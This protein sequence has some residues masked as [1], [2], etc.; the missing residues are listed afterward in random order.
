MALAT[1]QDAIHVSNMLKGSS[2]KIKQQEEDRKMETM[3]AI[4]KTKD[5]AAQELW[6][7]IEEFGGLY[8]VSN[9]GNVR[10]LKGNGEPKTMK[11]GHQRDLKVVWLRKNSTTHC[12]RV[13]RLVLEA[14]LGAAPGPR[15]GPAHQD[16]DMDNCHLDNMHWEDGLSRSYKK[17]KPVGR[18]KG[19]RKKI[20]IEPKP[21]PVARK[22]FSGVREQRILY[23]GN[24]EVIVNITDGLVDLSQQGSSPLIRLADVPDM[25]KVLQQ[26]GGK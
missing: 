9:F 23:C 11:P 12:R 13:D 8:E 10:S 20:D 15:F 21:K 2:S 24:V 17:R 26:I 6:M 14:F 4:Q 7:P 18:P 16:G 5:G 1:T 22:E 25:I 19:S 3:M